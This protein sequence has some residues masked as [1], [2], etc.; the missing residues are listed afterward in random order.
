MSSRCTMCVDKIE[1]M[2][3][4]DRDNM[5]NLMINQLMHHD[6]ITNK[7]VRQTQTTSELMRQTQTTS[8]L[9]RQTQKTNQLML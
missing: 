4:T 7:L 1:E 5:A 6:Q 3:K 8:E 9:M 2:V